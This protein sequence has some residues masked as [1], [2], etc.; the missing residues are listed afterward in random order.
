M[1]DLISYVSVRNRSGT[2]VKNVTLTADVDGDHRLLIESTSLSD[3]FTTMNKKYGFPIGSNI[4][5]GISF[6]LNDIE[7]TGMIKCPLAA[8]DNNQILNITLSDGNFTVAPRVSKSMTGLYSRQ[9]N[10]VAKA[11]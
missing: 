1:P 10:P 3:N 2:T 6:V 11:S 9:N 7:M 5:W 8:G 4:D